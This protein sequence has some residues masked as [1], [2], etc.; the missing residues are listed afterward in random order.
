MKKSILQST[1]ATG[2]LLLTGCAT[3][4]TYV[5]SSGSRLVANVNQINIQDF[6]NA[7]D[8]M[9][10]SLIDNL[11]NQGKLQSGVPSEPALLAVSRITNNTSRQFDTDRKS[12]RLNSSH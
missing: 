5:D 8:T 10:N 4:T 9:V 12:T 1:I 2:V 6:A 7:A 11:I 3:P